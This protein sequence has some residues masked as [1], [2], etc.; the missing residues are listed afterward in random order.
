MTKKYHN[1][2]LVWGKISSTKSE[3]KLWSVEVQKNVNKRVDTGTCFSAFSYFSFIDFGHPLIV[4]KKK[5]ND[6]LSYC[7]AGCELDSEIYSDGTEIPIDCN[8]W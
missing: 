6:E 2:I 3:C 1:C 4:W 8:S 7:G 5:L